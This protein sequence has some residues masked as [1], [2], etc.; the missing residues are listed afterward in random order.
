MSATDPKVT[1]IRGISSY[2]ESGA[3]HAVYR[4]G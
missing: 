2:P 4:G 3:V 1:L